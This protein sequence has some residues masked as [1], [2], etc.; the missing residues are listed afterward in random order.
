MVD[1]LVG[2]DPC[3]LKETIIVSSIVAAS[4]MLIALGFTKMYVRSFVSSF[5]CLFD[6]I[7][8]VPTRNVEMNHHN[9]MHYRRRRSV[10]LIKICEGVRVLVRRLLCVFVFWFVS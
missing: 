10:I 8:I 9:L 7:C 6:H 3:V 4:G 5:V 1:L 2:L